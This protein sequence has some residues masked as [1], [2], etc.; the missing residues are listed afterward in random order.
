MSATFSQLINIMEKGNIITYEKGCQARSSR[1]SPLIK[2]KSHGKES[3]SST[4]GP[5]TIQPMQ[6]SPM[7]AE[8]VSSIISLQTKPNL[9][10]SVRQN[11]R[12]LA[13]GK[14]MRKVTHWEK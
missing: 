3:E 2:R 12:R 13:I 14:Q 11:L 8:K 10:N 5:S 4:D 1:G 9:S 7:L 6:D